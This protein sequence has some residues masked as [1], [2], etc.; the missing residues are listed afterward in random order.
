MCTTGQVGGR[1]TRVKVT[2]SYSAARV[3]SRHTVA[4]TVTTRCGVYPPR[5]TF[6]HRK[7]RC[8]VQGT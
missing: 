5:P 2:I 8:K 4:L 7:Q 1:Q 6:E 3:S